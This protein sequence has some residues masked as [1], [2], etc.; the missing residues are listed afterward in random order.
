ML[1]PGGEILC[2]AQQ[3]LQDVK[4]FTDVPGFNSGMEAL[5]RLGISVKH[6]GTVT[7]SARA[8]P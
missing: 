8:F 3:T 2:D 6:V 1:Q 4:V 7:Y 5:D